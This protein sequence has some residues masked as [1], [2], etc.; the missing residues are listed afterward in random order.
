MQLPQ[1]RSDKQRLRPSSASGY[2]ITTDGLW[3]LKNEHG[4]CLRTRP[5][6]ADEVA[7]LAQ[8]GDFSENAEYQDAEHRLRSLN[9]RVLRLEDKIKNAKVIQTDHAEKNRVAL[10]STVMVEINGA[11]RTYQIVGPQ[12]TNPSRGR[13]SHVSPLGAHLMNSS[14]NDVV[15]IQTPSGEQR[16]RI[17]EIG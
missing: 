17:V 4:R 10:G 16:Y 2:Y 14:V 11:R 8:L 13:I 7:R 9:D 6:L 3:R 5:S 1:R 12:E 15:V